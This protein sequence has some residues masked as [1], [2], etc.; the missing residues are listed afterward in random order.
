MVE[1]TLVGEQGRQLSGGQCQRICVARALLARPSLLVLDEPTAHLDPQAAE[2]LVADVIAAAGD[3]SVLL[4]THRPEGLDLVDRV[5][6]LSG[7]RITSAGPR[8]SGA[9]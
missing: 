3:A 4:I 2:G 5:L 1:H 8:V 9:A 7:G 6:E